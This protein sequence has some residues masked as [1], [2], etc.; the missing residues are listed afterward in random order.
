MG[1][2]LL[3]ENTM[4]KLNGIKKIKYGN[5]DVCMRIKKQ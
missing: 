2:K 3:L 4:Q 5:K 1:I